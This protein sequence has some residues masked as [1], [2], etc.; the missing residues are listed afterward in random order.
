[1]H[2][3]SPLTG[4]MRVLAANVCHVPWCSWVSGKSMAEG[5]VQSFGNLYKVPGRSVSRGAQ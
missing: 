1:M 4:R 3:L 5:L 2:A